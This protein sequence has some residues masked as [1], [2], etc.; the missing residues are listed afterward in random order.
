MAN[1]YKILGQVAPAA[2]TLSNVYVVPTAT[3]AV[4]SS[5][6]ICNRGT[7]NGTYSI[8]VAEDDAA[9]NVKQYIASESVVPAFDSISLTLGLTLSANDVVRCNSTSA[10]LTFS[11]FGSEIT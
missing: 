7:G 9:D 6:V 5:L 2:N 4:V 8:S 1:I 3:Q 11:A 10:N